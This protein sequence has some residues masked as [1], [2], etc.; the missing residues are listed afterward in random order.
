MRGKRGGFS[1]FE[2]LV[3]TLIIAL[4][5]AILVP[6]LTRARL[7]AKRTA[8]STN[9]KQASI[10]LMVYLE[11]C[12]DYPSTLLLGKR[13]RATDPLTQS[14]PGPTHIFHCPL[15]VPQGRYG[16]PHQDRREPKSYAETWFLWEG[17][18][19][20]AAWSRLLQVEPNPIVFRCYFHD[21][22]VRGLLLSPGF[23]A[24]FGSMFNGLA[25]VAREDGSVTL[26]RRSDTFWLPDRSGPD[27]KQ[28][29][30]YAATE[31]PCPPDI[32]DGN[33]IAGGGRQY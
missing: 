5:I 27:V 16:L 14:S 22:R 3:V 23:L 4:L 29:Y 25:L 9:L 8:C 13:V 11:E 2:V 31:K 21:D 1:L 24:D 6:V 30:W 32:C 12:G 33:P 19:G 15:D 17:E 20:I 28:T 7:A 26:D 18:Q 10:A